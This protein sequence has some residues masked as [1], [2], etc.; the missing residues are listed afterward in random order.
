MDISERYTFEDA[1]KYIKAHQ[2]TKREIKD[3]MKFIN[4]DTEEEIEVKTTITSY[5]HTK[6]E[7]VKNPWD[8]ETHFNIP[9]YIRRFQE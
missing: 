6:E 4:L 9:A 2:P 7:G 5:A 8:D 3:F 1:Q